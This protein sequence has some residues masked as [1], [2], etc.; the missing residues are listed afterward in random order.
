MIDERNEELRKK[1]PFRV[2]RLDLCECGHD[3]SDHQTE[4]TLTKIEDGCCSL[5]VC[6]KFTLPMVKK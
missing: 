3:D 4:R 1:F 5:C 2:I 6:K